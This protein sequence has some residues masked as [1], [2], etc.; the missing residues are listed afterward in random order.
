MRVV[1]RDAENHTQTPFRRS[2][3]GNEPTDKTTKEA[4]EERA[5]RLL[6]GHDG[7]LHDIHQYSLESKNTRKTFQNV[8]V[9][10]YYIHKFKPQ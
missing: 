9:L 1:L 6:D 8:L 4:I 3:V 10:L 7:H 2:P 5:N